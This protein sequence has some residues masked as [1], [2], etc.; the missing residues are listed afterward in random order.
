MTVSTRTC[1]HCRITVPAPSNPAQIIPDHWVQDPRTYALVC[2]NCHTR[3]IHDG[4]RP[5]AR[6]EID[7]AKKNH[8]LV[9][10]GKGMVG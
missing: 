2:G 4:W 9:L 7:Q 10:I 8:R 3:R 1:S 6:H 5:P